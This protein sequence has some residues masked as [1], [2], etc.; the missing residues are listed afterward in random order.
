MILVVFLWVLQYIIQLY[1]IFS[2]IG[3]TWGLG[4]SPD[5]PWWI[6][7]GRL[8]SNL[9]LF[10]MKNGLV[11]VTLFGTLRKSG[12]TKWNPSKQRKLLMFQIQNICSVD[13]LSRKKLL[14]RKTKKEDRPEKHKKRTQTVVC[15]KLSTFLWNDPIEDIVFLGHCLEMNLFTCQLL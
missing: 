6:C 5:S 14:K 11:I 1:E 15:L 2:L 12:I 3:T 7:G 13:K 10:V 4:A 8:G 9:L